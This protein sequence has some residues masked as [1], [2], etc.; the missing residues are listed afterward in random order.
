VWCDRKDC[1]LSK[2]DHVLQAAQGSEGAPNRALSAGTTPRRRTSSVQDRRLGAQSFHVGILFTW[3]KSSRQPRSGYR[4]WASNCNSGVIRVVTML[5]GC[6]F[7]STT[8][9]HSRKEPSGENRVVTQGSDSAGWTTCPGRHARDKPRFTAHAAQC[10][11]IRVTSH[12]CV[13]LPAP[14]PFSSNSRPSKT[15]VHTPSPS[16]IAYRGTH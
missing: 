13:G 4:R 2:L 12:S 3:M 15:K 8:S 14:V 10:G 5:C 9:S 11:K 16:S 1:L 6:S 7:H